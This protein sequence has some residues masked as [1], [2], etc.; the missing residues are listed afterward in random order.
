MAFSAL[1]GFIYY[2][3][4]SKYATRDLRRTFFKPTKYHFFH[5]LFLPS[6]EAFHFP[7]VI[8]C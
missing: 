5:D 1:N 4:L 7:H 3:L 6:A 8:L 2:F